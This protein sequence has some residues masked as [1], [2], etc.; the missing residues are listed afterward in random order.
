MEKVGVGIELS[1]ARHA[2]LCCFGAGAGDG[3]FADGIVGAL[4]GDHHGGADPVVALVICD[5]ARDHVDAV[6]VSVLD[7]HNILKL[8]L[9]EPARVKPGC[10]SVREVHGADR[11][12]IV[13]LNVLGEDHVCLLLESQQL[14][15]G[16]ER[17]LFTLWEELVAPGTPVVITVSVEIVLNKLTALVLVH[18]QL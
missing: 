4:L 8:L 15:R 12:V 3:H 13:Q 10:F 17:A 6:P 16:E 14:I 9:H 1:I 5:G 11:V 2:L 7:V 18:D